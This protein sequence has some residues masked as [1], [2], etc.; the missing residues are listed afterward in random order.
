MNTNLVEYYKDR[1]KEYEKIYLK[2]ERQNDI[3]SATTILQNTFSGK[4]VFEVACGTGFWTEKI[5][6]TTASVYATDI[7]KQLLKLLNRRNTK[8][9][10]SHLGL[11]I[12]LK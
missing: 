5:A 11:K 1:A 6:Q 10:M 12:F 7:M 8:I 3:I 2:P 9:K 4:N